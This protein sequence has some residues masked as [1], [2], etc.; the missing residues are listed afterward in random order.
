MLVQVGGA[1]DN[2]FKNSCTLD[3]WR[4]SLHSHFKAYLL[5]FCKGRHLQGMNQ[6]RLTRYCGPE[7]KP[8]FP[9]TLYLPWVSDYDEIPPELYYQF[10]LIA[11]QLLSLS[12]WPTSSEQVTCHFSLSRNAKWGNARMK[13]SPEHCASITQ[14]GMENPW[15]CFPFYMDWED[16]CSD[17]LDLSLVWADTGW[18]LSLFNT[19]GCCV[20]PARPCGDLYICI[21]NN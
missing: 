12:M 20:I 17:L 9:F 10:L 16:L 18:V 11:R 3:G 6:R 13:G 4:R 7:L 21:R 19:D 1:F 2:T 8:T 15:D 5:H 14:G